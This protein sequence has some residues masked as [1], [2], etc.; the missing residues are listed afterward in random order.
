[1][2]EHAINPDAVLAVLKG[3]IGAINGITAAD[4]VKELTGDASPADQRRLRDCVVLL[5]N[6][7]HAVCALPEAGYFMAANSDELNR[8]CRFLLGRA[9]TGLQQIAAMKNKAVPDLA[10]QLGLDLTHP[11]EGANHV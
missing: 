4:L 7:G 9:Q 10:G 6:Q 1:M 3:R 5:R 8:T 11:L 2:N